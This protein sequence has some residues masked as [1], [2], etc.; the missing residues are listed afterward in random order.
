M[1]EAPLRKLRSASRT[2]FAAVLG[3]ELSTK[4]KP[5]ARQAAPTKGILPIPAFITHL[6]GTPRKP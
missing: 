2:L 6:I 1:I 5:A 4:M 3:E